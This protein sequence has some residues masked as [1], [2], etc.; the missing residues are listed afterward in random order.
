M[1]YGKTSE[2]PEELAQNCVES[3]SITSGPLIIPN[4]IVKYK[5]Y[6]PVCHSIYYPFKTAKESI[7]SACTENFCIIFKIK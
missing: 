6:G 3:Y 4:K 2:M 7:Q 5:T 1:Y